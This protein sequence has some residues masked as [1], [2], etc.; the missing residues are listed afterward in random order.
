MT[1][2]ISPPTTPLNE[3]VPRGITNIR[4]SA[5]RSSSS[6]TVAINRLTP[7]AKKWAVGVRHHRNVTDASMQR[8]TRAVNKL[9]A[10]NEI[11]L[12]AL[13]SAEGK[14][15]GWYASAKGETDAALWLSD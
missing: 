7:Q 14:E 13:A 10:Q 12:K 5:W 15:I 4:V 6:N 9:L 3:Q 2:V 11:V 8:L 1:I